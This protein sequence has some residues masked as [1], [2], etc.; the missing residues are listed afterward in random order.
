[1]TVR[2][3]NTNEHPVAALV[4]APNVSEGARPSHSLPGRTGAAKICTILVLVPIGAISLLRGDLAFGETAVQ[5]QNRPLA[6]SAQVT[7]TWSHHAREGHRLHAWAKYFEAEQA[8]RGALKQAEAVGVQD[9][10]LAVILANLGSALNGQARH[11]S[12]AGVAPCL[13]AFREVR[14]LRTN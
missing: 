10:R 7:P 13:G 2:P 14:R 12:A 11:A 3:A 8:F 6:D 1:M 9:T 5:K 4:A